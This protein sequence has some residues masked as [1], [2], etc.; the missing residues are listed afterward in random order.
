MIV[1]KTDAGDNYS[2]K[3]IPIRSTEIKNGGFNTRTSLIDAESSLPVELA[4]GKPSESDP[5]EIVTEHTCRVCYGESY[6]IEDPLI[7]VCSCTGS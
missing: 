5:A 2:D 1:R 4:E 7:S 6:T 3:S